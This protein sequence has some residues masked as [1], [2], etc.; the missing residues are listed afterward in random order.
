MWMASPV[1]AE[2]ATAWIVDGT[3]EELLRRQRA[4]A[5]A[6]QVIAREY[7]EGYRVDSHPN[8]LC[9]WLHLPEPWRAERFVRV[10]RQRGVA[11]T[12][13]EAFVVGRSAAPHA[14]RVCLGAA[15]DRAVLRQA[16]DTLAHVLKEAPE[17]G[18]AF[19]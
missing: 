8:S 4:E 19:V 12:S 3:A 6:R 15:P 9:V 1:T 13:A 5:A 7:L 17:P 16:L 14:A 10:V 11:V 18:Y 2:I